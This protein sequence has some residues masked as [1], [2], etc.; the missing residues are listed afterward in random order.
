MN[1]FD[2]I[3]RSD[4]TILVVDS[5][6]GLTEQD[7]RL[8]GF[9][10]EEGKPS[11]ILMNKWD[12]VEKDTYTMNEFE[13]K[14]KE[15]LKFMDY[16]VSLY[17]SALTGKRIE[18]LMDLVNEVYEKS[19]YRISTGNLNEIMQNAILT[20][21]PP[22]QNGRRLKIKYI[23]QGGTNPPTFIIFVNNK[24]LMHFSYLRYLENSIRKAV[25]FKGT[26]I[27]LFVKD[28]KEKE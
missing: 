7:V 14:L 18:K 4:V 19:S 24:E 13:T 25:D 9:I 10:H 28:G 5:V 12:M 22:T 23:T 15:D 21:E 26:P 27:K 2:A 6:D 20:N 8:A 3:R 1:T 16:Y 11:I 17:A